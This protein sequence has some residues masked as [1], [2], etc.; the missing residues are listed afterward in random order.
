MNNK[1]RLQDKVALVT[2]AGQGI[3]RATAIRLAQEGSRVAVNGRIAHP[4]IENVVRETDGIP[5]I[6]DIAQVGQVNTMVKEV[7]EQ[8]GPIEI[9]VA[10]AARMTML[11]F[12]EQDAAEWWEQ[13]DINRIPDIA[14]GWVR[15]ALELSTSPWHRIELVGHDITFDELLIRP[16]D[17][18]VKTL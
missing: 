13:I 10:N 15:V 12:L 18:F 17:I 4:K 9:L 16:S 2:G 6:A 5:V 3:G 8:L 11:P 7:E 1:S 14:E